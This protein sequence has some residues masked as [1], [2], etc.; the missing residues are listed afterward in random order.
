MLMKGAEK[1]SNGPHSVI[2]G[3]VKPDHIDDYS[4][5]AKKASIDSNCYS[6]SVAAMIF[7]PMLRW[8]SLTLRCYYFSAKSIKTCIFS[9]VFAER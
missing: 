8:Y 1:F 5:N 7:N 3:A 2:I 4:W 6:F 9:T